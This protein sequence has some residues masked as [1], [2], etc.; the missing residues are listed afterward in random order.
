[1]TA[2]IIQA[3]ASANHPKPII[4]NRKPTP[5]ARTAVFMLIDKVACILQDWIE[6][7]HTRRGKDHQAHQ[8][9]RPSLS[10]KTPPHPSANPKRSWLN[11]IRD[12]LPGVGGCVSPGC[13]C[14]VP[15]TWAELR[16]WLLGRHVLTYLHLLRLH[17]QSNLV[18]SPRPFTTMLVDPSVCLNFFVVLVVPLLQ[19]QFGTYLKS[20]R[21]RCIPP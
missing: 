8:D 20:R 4:L 15:G 21:P 17:C 1:M 6:E 9:K 16:L 11:L 19:K 10:M 5:F 3:R 7:K 2:L 12:K 14:H 13:A 18:K